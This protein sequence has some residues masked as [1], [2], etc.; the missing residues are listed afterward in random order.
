MKVLDNK[1]LDK[2]K[3]R[4]VEIRKFYKHLVSYIVFNL[5][6]TFL[7][8]ASFNFI[9]DIKFSNRF[10]ENGFVHF[11]IWYLW[12]FFLLIHAI[13]TFAFSNVFIQDWENKKIEEFI[14]KE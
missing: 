2:A 10:D 9:E 13:K 3:L 7:V 12:G 1:K 11:P 6:F 4:I 8:K 14:N 5:V